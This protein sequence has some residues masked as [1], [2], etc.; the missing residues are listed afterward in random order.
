MQLTYGTPKGRRDHTENSAQES[1]LL[2]M[3]DKRK[4]DDLL[5]PR[6]QDPSSLLEVGNRDAQ[7]LRL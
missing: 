7:F 2:F 3:G 6:L 5:L 4:L 1:T